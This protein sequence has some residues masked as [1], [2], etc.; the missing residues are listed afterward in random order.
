MIQIHIPGHD[1]LLQSSASSV[2]PLHGKPPLDGGG[3]LH[4][5]DLVR[6]PLPQLL[7]HPIQFVHDSHL[8]S[9]TTIVQFYYKTVQ[10]SGILTWIVDTCAY[11]KKGINRVIQNN[12]PKSLVL[13]DVDF[14]LC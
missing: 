9:M 4:V 1:I 14:V 7:L 2:S 10:R 8:P 3:L 13:Y 6:S 5:R 11:C 12:D